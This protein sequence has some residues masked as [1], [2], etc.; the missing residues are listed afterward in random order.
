MNTLKKLC[1]REDAGSNCVELLKDGEV[2]ITR[3]KYTTMDKPHEFK[4]NDYE[5]A[6]L[7][8]MKIALFILSD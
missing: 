3:Y 8:F 5:H 2:Y 1:T 6:C 4:T 7:D